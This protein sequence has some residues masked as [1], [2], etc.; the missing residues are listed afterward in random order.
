MR[1]S[2][3]ETLLENAKPDVRP[4][5]VC[6]SINISEV[7]SSTSEAAHVKATPVDPSDRSA[8]CTVVEGVEAANPH[9]PGCFCQPT[10]SVTSGGRGLVSD[11]GAG[12]RP[13]IARRYKWAARRVSD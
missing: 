2:V 10:S 5:G 7:T 12:A 1:G 3:I 4:A 9:V 8:F 6:F 11:R 13:A